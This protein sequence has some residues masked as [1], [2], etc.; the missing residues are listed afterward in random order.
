LSGNKSYFVRR[1]YSNGKFLG[2]QTNAIVKT[3]ETKICALLCADILPQTRKMKRKI[4]IIKVEHE[5]I[6]LRLTAKNKGVQSFNK[7]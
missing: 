3:L 6:R 2:F 4:D 7:F 5:N 1:R